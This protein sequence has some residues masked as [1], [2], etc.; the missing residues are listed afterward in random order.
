[1]HCLYGITVSAKMIHLIHLDVGLPQTVRLPDEDASVPIGYIHSAQGY[2][3][4]QVS[5]IGDNDIGRV[6]LW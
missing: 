1:M 4:Y 2:M 5:I 6:Y 3:S